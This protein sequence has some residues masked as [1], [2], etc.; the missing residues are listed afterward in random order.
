LAEF[1]RIAPKRIQMDMPPR[2]VERLKVLQAKTE[3]SSY[4]EVVRNALRLY[5]ALIDEVESG[6]KILVERDGAVSPLIIFGS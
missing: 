5:E 3:A 2:S 1:E 4:A 6:S